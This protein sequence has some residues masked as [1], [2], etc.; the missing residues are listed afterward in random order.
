MGSLIFPLPAT[1]IDYNSKLRFDEIFFLPF[2][3]ITGL[4]I[5]PHISKSRPNLVENHLS[6]IL[7]CLLKCD[8]PN[9]LVRVIVD[10]EEMSLSVSSTVLLGELLHLANLLLPR[11]VSL[12]LLN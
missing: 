6:L 12:I 4:D 11:E 3:K 7:H 9:V 2:K 8:L 5:L 1:V 10:T